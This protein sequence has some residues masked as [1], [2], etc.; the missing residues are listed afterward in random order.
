M[1]H[2]I[3]V[4]CALVAFP[5]VH[6]FHSNVGIVPHLSIGLSPFL[7]VLVHFLFF[8]VAP[9]WGRDVIYA[10]FVPYRNDADVNCICN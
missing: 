2:I 3:L 10:S 5:P 8:W 6:A 4:I 7:G 9:S 1:L